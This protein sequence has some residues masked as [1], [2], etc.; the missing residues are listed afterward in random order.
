MEYLDEQEEF[1]RIIGREVESDGIV[2]AN[3]PLASASHVN[4]NNV[5]GST[6]IYFTATWCGPCKNIASKLAEIVAQNPHIRWL[7]CDVDRNGYTPG[8]CGVKG[9]PA[10]MAIHNTKIVGQS[11]ISDGGKLADWVKQIF[12]KGN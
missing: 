3:A 8:F 1:E 10:F 5:S 12:P 9:I 4:K 7:K 6:V 2:A 11:Q